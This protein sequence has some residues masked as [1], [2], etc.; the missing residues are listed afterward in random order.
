MGT[1]HQGRKLAMQTLYQVATRSD[2]LED[3][4]DSFFDESKVSEDSQNFGR[5]LAIAAWGFKDIADEYVS[6]YAEGW[7]LDRISVV[8]LSVLRLAFYE[9]IK[10]D[11][12]HNIVLNEA[13]ELT[14]EFSSPESPKF[15]NG[16]LG[17][18]VKDHVHG[19]H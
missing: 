18:Y 14:K 6:K 8:D 15:I 9:L 16:I 12:P 4:I 11:T 10:T 2:D 5:Q 19:N 13:V 1:R 3:L 7:T 17:Q